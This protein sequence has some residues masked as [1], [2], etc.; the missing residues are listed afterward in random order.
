LERLRL[1]DAFRKIVFTLRC[2][3]QCDRLS[4]AA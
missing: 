1:T 2:R 4:A 3:A